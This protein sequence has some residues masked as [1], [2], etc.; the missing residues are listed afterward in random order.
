[1]VYSE[2]TSTMEHLAVSSTAYSYFGSIFSGISEPDTVKA[3]Q[4]WM[5]HNNM[6][7]INTATKKSKTAHQLILLL[8]QCVKHGHFTPKPFIW[9]LLQ[10]N[11]CPL[12]SAIWKSR[13]SSLAP[14]LKVTGISHCSS[15]ETFHFIRQHDLKTLR[16]IHQSCTL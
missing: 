4:C 7:W 13:Q 16:G 10:L 11:H 5:K 2:N 12:H 15:D 14:K 6:F 8:Q 3:F 1:M 9:L